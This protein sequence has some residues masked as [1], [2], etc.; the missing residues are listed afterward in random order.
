[1][2]LAKTRIL[3]SNDDGIHGP[4][5]KILEEIARSLSDDVWVVAPETEQSAMSHSLTLRRPL[6]VRNLGERRFAVVGT[7]TDCVPMAQRQILKER[8]A[9]LVLSG[10]NEG[11]NLGEDV[12]YSGTIAAAMEGTLLGA[13]AIALSQGRSRNQPTA[14]ETAARFGPDLVRRLVGQGWPQGVLMNVNFPPRS[15]EEVRGI[16][17]CEQGRHDSGI[18]IH[19]GRDPSGRPYSWIGNF[20]EPASAKVGTDI[21]AFYAGAITVSPL[22]FDRTERNVMDDLKGLFE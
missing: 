7:P 2:D 15:P 19:Q 21:A 20:S 6:R 8:P 10:V 11:S 16:E 13:A 9:D 4:G 14:W 1:M 18:E 17:I 12:A 5:L 3:I 22:R